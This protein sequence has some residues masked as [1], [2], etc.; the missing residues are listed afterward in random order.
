MYEHEPRK[1]EKR[2][3]K[4]I[5]TVENLKTKELSELEA[6]GVFVFI[7]GGQ[8]HGDEDIGSGNDGAADGFVA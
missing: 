8:V 3:D 2:G 7:V 5:T 6:D 1:F 4:M